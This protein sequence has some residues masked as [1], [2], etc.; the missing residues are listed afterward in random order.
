MVAKDWNMIWKASCTLLWP[1]TIPRFWGSEWKL[2]ELVLKISSPLQQSTCWRV[3]PLRWLRHGSWTG[4]YLP[5]FCFNHLTSLIGASST[6][7]GAF[8]T[9]TSP[10]YR[11]GQISP[12]EFPFGK[13][14]KHSYF[15]FEVMSTFFFF[16]L[17]NFWGICLVTPIRTYFSWW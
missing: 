9:L 10:L 14:I 13:K 5:G 11:P 6:L 4:F 3:C 7:P 8:P 1:Q 2:S 17:F 16:W 12:H 15:C